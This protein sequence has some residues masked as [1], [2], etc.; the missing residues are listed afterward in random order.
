MYS[1]KENS[2]FKVNVLFILIIIILLFIT[3]TIIAIINIQ[4]SKSNIFDFTYDGGIYEPD[5]SVI[6]SYEINLNKKESTKYCRSTGLLFDE[7]LIEEYGYNKRITR[8]LSEDEFNTI[9]Q[10]LNEPNKYNAEISIEEPKYILSNDN[11]RLYIPLDDEK[12][13][14]LESI[15]T[16]YES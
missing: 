14:I 15:T 16:G 9:I 5:D 6:W 11:I 2:I 7:E 4:K 10:I 1:K 3:T 13:N 12:L 8:A